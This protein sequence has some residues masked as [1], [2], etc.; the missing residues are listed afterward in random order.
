MQKERGQILSVEKGEQ[1]SRIVKI[2][3][4]VTKANNKQTNKTLRSAARVKL[5]KYDTRGAN[6]DIN[7]GQK[8]Y[9]YRVQQSAVHYNDTSRWYYLQWG[10]NR[11]LRTTENYKFEKRNITVYTYQYIAKF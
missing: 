1:N 4:S 11:Q 3:L 7:K 9:T 6:N 5:P 2:R 8:L 10:R